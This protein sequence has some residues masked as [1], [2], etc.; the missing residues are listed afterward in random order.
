MLSAIAF[1]PPANR[2][3]SASN[4]AAIAYIA[5]ADPTIQATMPHR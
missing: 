4:P 2:L 1:A 3:T 5:T